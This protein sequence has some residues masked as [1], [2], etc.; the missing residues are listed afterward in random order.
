LNPSSRASFARRSAFQI[1]MTQNITADCHA[2]L[3][4]VD[5]HSRQNR[6]SQ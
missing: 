2:P 3:T 4:L 5:W 1:F 6:G